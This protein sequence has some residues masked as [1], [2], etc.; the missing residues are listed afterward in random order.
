MLDSCSHVAIRDLPAATLH[1]IEPLELSQ[2]HRRR[3]LVHPV[4]EPDP[5][6]GQPVA[7]FGAALVDEASQLDRDRVVVGRD[8]PA[9]GG[10][11]LLVGIEAV[12]G[13]VPVGADVSA[14][15][16]RADGFAGILDHR[17]PVLLGNHVDRLDVARI[18]KDVDRHDRPGARCDGGLDRGRIEVQ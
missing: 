7:V 1:V 12:H 18:A 8:Q 9:L 15:N 13:G 16:R 17:Q 5:R 3:H 4:V 14:A 6:V 10:G 11:Q 2:A